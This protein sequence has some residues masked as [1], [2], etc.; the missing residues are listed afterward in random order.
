M[1]TPFHRQVSEASRLQALRASGLL[2][3]IAQPEFERVTTLAARVLNVPV[4]LV[5]L[6]DSER[7]VFAGACGLSDPY[8]RDRET[9]LSHSFCQHAVNE[10]RPLIIRDARVDPRVADNGA[11]ADL[12]VIAYLGFPLAGEDDHLF[13]AFCVIDSKPRDWTE[14]E[15]ES[16]RDFTALVA[17]QIELLIARQREKNALE[18]VVHDLKS[19]LAG[20]KMATNL[21]RERAGTMPRE[22]NPLVEALGESSDHASRLVDSLVRPSRQSERGQDLNGVLSQVIERHRPQA[23]GKGLTLE[24]RN[25][26]PVVRLAA[27]DWVIERVADNLLSNAIKFTPTGGTVRLD[28]VMDGEGGGFEISD[29]GPGFAEED[30]PKIFSRYARLSARPTAGEASTGLG[31]SMVKRLVDEEGGSVSLISAPGEGAVFRIFFPLAGE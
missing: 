3:G 12:G 21:L 19:P 9:P 1:T 24:H 23:A 29:T 13:G 17:G 22:L 25:D 30:L 20:I 18:I 31:L 2:D 15:I 6:V 14:E 8:N 11:I 10:G 5:S 4:C 28:W 16:V 27:A 7:Q 26:I